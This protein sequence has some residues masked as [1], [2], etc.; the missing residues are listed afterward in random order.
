MELS[1]NF[2]GI[3]NAFHRADL[4]SNL[5]AVHLYATVSG[6][7]RVSQKITPRFLDASSRFPGLVVRTPMAELRGSTDKEIPVPSIFAELPK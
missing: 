7:P 4:E 1:W 3:E 6:A 2:S 5:D